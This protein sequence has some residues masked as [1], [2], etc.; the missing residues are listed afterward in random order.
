MSGQNKSVLIV[1]DNEKTMRLVRDVLNASG[2]STYCALNGKE[3]I[4]IALEKL[5][6]LIIMDIQM[7]VMGGIEATKILKETNVTK[8]IPVIALTSYAMKGDREKLMNEG[9]DGYLSKPFNMEEFLNIVSV[10]FG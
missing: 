4:E 7:P 6:D 10:N 8:K 1:E 2:Y 3:G 5:P 9:F